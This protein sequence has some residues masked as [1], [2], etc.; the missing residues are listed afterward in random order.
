[1]I[2]AS[3]ARLSRLEQVKR[4]SLQA[5]FP[6]PGQTAPALRFKGFTGE[7]KRVKL[8]EIGYTYSGIAGKGK[9]DF[10]I[11]NSKYITFLNVLNNAIIDTN[12]LESVNINPG[13]NQNLVLKGDLL[14]NTSSETPDE[15]GLCAV[16]DSDI[17]DVYL[18][19]FCFGYRL[20][21]NSIDANFIATYMRSHCG[22]SLMRVLAQGATRYNLSKTNFLA[23]E[24][25]VPACKA[26]Q[27]A[28]GAYFKE[29]DRQLQLEGAKLGKLRQLKQASLSQLFV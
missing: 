5:M 13:E 18:N 9:S 4:G 12:I 20:T 11:G 21:D 19:S 8:G 25:L 7:W 3:T 27:E 14:F 26:E 15:V 10:G 28:I 6:L 2:A 23:S 24:I 17:N 1:M 22:R 29:L 16:F